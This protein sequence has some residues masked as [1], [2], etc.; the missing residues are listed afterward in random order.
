[1]MMMQYEMMTQ[2]A[3]CYIKLFNER[4]G[5]KKYNICLLIVAEWKY[6]SE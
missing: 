2:H 4:T 3:I 5:V 1:M 6:K